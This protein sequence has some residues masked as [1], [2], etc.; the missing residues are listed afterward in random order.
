MVA[1][2]V[3]LMS[4]VTFMKYS[5]HRPPA[6]YQANGNMFPG[7]ELVF[8]ASVSFNDTPQ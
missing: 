1:M 5:K 7:N 6:K 2:S 8:I 4:V 3:T